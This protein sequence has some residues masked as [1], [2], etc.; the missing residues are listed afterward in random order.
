MSKLDL[1][2]TGPF[3]PA[4][5]L[6]WLTLASKELKWFTLCHPHWSSAHFDLEWS[7]P[8]PIPCKSLEVPKGIRLE[9]LNS[10]EGEFRSKRAIADMTKPFSLADHRLWMVAKAR[11]GAR[12]LDW[13]PR[14]PAGLATLWISSKPNEPVLIESEV[15]VPYEE[16]AQANDL[17]ATALSVAKLRPDDGWTLEKS[18]K[19]GS[20]WNCVKIEAVAQR[21]GSEELARIVRQALERQESLISEVS[22]YVDFLE[23][24]ERISDSLG[25]SRLIAKRAIIEAAQVS[26][27]YHEW[28]ELLNSAQLAGKK[29]TVSFYATVESLSDF[30]AVFEFC[31]QVKSR[32]SGALAIFETEKGKQGYI[33]FEVKP[34][35]IKFD[36]S[37]GANGW[38]RIHDELRKTGGR[39]PFYC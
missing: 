23:N 36:V 8:Y 39:L 5:A 11:M 25:R 12:I 20:N 21:G 37:Y 14:E 18:S 9:A 2:K 24:F 17:F 4:E 32:A 15:Y 13:P 3:T 19:V 16:G 26:E 27:D 29:A 38:E 28:I 6:E 10:V 7:T 22:W 1:R 34:K 30:R 35:G 31:L 33:E